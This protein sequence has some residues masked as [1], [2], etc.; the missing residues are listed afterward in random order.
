MRR[1]LTLLALCSTA[2]LVAAAAPGASEPAPSAEL[3]RPAADGVIGTTTVTLVTG[4]RLRVD[5]LGNGRH[6]VTALPAPGSVRTNLKVVER[7]EGLYAI[8]AE[9]EPYLAAGSLDRELFNVTGLIDQGYDGDSLPLIVTYADGGA[10]RGASPA[11]EAPEHAVV[12]ATLGRFQRRDRK[13]TRLNS[14]H[15]AVSRMP[16]SA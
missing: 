5:A 9:A 4:H 15:L 10:A 14:S 3:P 13:S 6:A 2:V 7:P 11:L 16:S 1:T 12:T 8:P